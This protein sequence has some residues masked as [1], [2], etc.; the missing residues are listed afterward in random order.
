MSTVSDLKIQKD[1]AS[2]PSSSGG[3]LAGRERSSEAVY[4]ACEDRKKL[5]AIKKRLKVEKDEACSGSCKCKDCAGKS[6]QCKNC[7][8]K[9]SQD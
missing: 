4:F 6:C 8:K 1:C 9:K 3:A 5:A 7:K 2:N